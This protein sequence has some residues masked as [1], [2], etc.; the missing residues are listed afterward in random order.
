MK[1]A[2]SAVVLALL[3]VITYESISHSSQYTELVEN[4]ALLNYQI[5]E[6]TKKQS[7]THESLLLETSTRQ[8]E[9][10]TLKPEED[11]TTAVMNGID[12]F[13]DSKWVVYYRHSYCQKMVFKTEAEAKEEYSKVSKDYAKIIFHD[14]KVIA[15]YGGAEWT[16]NCI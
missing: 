8:D 10:A 2:A 11:E 12:L 3:G 15:K 9:I 16:R 7:F 5:N 14:G 4:N 6:L 13:N 1:Y